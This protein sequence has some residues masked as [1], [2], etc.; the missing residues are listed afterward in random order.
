MNIIVRT[1]EE[2]YIVRPDTTWERDNEDIYVPEFVNRL[3][4]TPVLF[5]RVSKPGRSIGREFAERYYDGVGYGVLLYPEDMCD[6]SETGFACASCLDHTSFLPFP[7]Y[8]KVTL[9][10]PG[11]VFEL[12]INDSVKIFS[13]SGA[14]SA[15]IRDAIAEATRYIYIRTGDIIAIE[16]QPRKPLCA[17]EKNENSAVWA[18]EGYTLCSRAS[19]KAT[20][21]ENET[22]DFD[23]IF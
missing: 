9:D 23:I 14:S 21:C 11:N 7:V 18:A 15:A 1:A 17:R 22:I 12:K 8:N 2:K 16:L 6:G 4:W 10:R 19:L 13:H 5:A 20:F 3:T